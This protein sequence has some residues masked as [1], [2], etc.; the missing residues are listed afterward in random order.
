M[1]IISTIVLLTITLALFSQGNLQFNKAVSLTLT[2]SVVT[3]TSTNFRQLTVPTPLSITVPTGK[4]L[5]ITSSSINYLISGT[6][7]THPNYIINFED[8]IW[9]NLLLDDIVISSF[10]SESSISPHVFTNLNQPIWLPTGTYILSVNKLTQNV[11][12]TLT[13]KI[14][15]HLSGIEFNII[16]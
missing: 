2:S 14:T 12:S 15:G 9:S 13:Q 4:T 10:R 7:S 1:K 5:K 16:P 8:P 11:H 3:T 6:Y